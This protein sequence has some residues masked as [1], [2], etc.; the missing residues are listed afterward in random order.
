MITLRLAHSPDSDDLVMWWPLTGMRDA[1]GEPVPG[2]R[3]EPA[4]D[5][6]R[7]RFV[8]RGDDVETLNKAALAG[9]ESF[10][11]TAISAAA[12]PRLADKWLITACGGSFG[13]GYGPK[14]VVREDSRIRDL[15]S[16]AAVLRGGGVLAIPGRN[17]TAFLTLSLALSASS[18]A[19]E[20][21]PRV[22]ELPFAEIPG[23]VAEG[24][25]AAGLLIHEAQ[26][27]FADLG[28][29]PVLDLGQWWDGQTLLPLPL[30]LNVIRRDLDARFGDGACDEVALLLHASVHHARTNLDDSKRYLRL[31]AAGR[32]EWHDDALVDRY[33]SMYVSDL[34]E[35]MGERGRNALRELYGRASAAGLCPPTDPE[36][37]G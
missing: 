20:T 26:L 31:H 19:G 11:I 3:G 8:T 13:E 2:T 21:L 24:R 36:V 25:A 22:D 6:G 4:I 1:S 15:D 37:I 23:A 9:D 18:H 35:D 27:T 12:Y 28:L 30:G 29:R 16:L 14:V 33:L 34:T 32:E 7:F 5:T 10:D 17:T